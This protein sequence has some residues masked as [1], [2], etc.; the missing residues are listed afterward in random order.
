MAEQRFYALAVNHDGEAMI[1]GRINEATRSAAR[2][3]FQ[4]KTRPTGNGSV[5]PEWFA[6]GW[7]AAPTLAIQICEKSAE[8]LW[9]E[10]SR[11]AF[12][13]DAIRAEHLEAAQ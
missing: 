9:R 5:D 8:D 1:L 12:P 10:V 7:Y 2:D 3:R 6:G 13:N 4:Q 11:E